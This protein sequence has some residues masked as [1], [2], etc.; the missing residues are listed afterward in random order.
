MNCLHSYAKLFFYEGN[1]EGCLLI[2]GFTGTP[3]HM[4]LLGEVLKK[5]GYTVNGI[6][7]KGHGT[8]VEDMRK[9]NWK[10]WMKDAL[11]GYQK[12]R[13]KCS[14]VYVIGLSM[15]GVLSL[16]LAEKY[17]VDKIISIAAPIRIYD[18]FAR[19]SPIVKYFMPY[20]KWKE[21]LPQK[22]ENTAYK[23]AYTSIPVGTVPSLL[24]LMKQ[25]KSNLSKITCPT[26]II[27]SQKDQTV[28]PISAQIIYDSISSKQKE[29]LWL[30]QSKHVCTLGPEREYMH[31]KIIEFLQR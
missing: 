1:D 17:K 12:L 20:K 5:Q 9:C 15:G 22:E 24:K 14:K 31:R 27:Q 11:D 25:A 18:R 28:K 19:F 16:L 21:S 7:L 10:D 8:C 4:R 13:D 29:I 23:I 26:M 2:H 30:K 6:L 3:A